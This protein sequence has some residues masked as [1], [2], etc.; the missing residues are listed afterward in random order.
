MRVVANDLV[1]ST[2]SV[3]LSRTPLQPTTAAPVID[4]LV[5]V[6]LSTTKIDQT[7]QAF[8]DF[9]LI[10]PTSFRYFLTLTF[11]P[12]AVP[13]EAVVETVQLTFTPA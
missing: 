2:A 7:Q 3:V 6:D 9:A 10:D 5:E 8:A 12:L 4:N 11:T 13:S 1:S